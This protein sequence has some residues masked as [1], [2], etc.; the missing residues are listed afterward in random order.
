LIKLIVSDLDGTLLGFDKKI[1]E[2]DKRAIQAAIEHG[3]DFAV[4]SGR[5]DIEI[6]EVLKEIEQKAHRVSQNGAYIYTK[7]DVSLH[8][9]TFEPTVARQ[10]Y[11]EAKQLE[12]IILVCNENTNFVETLTEQVRQL[13]VRLFHDIIEAPNMIKA[14][15]TTIYPSKITV[16]AE[17]DVITSFQQ[18]VTKQF[19]DLVDT[20]ISEERCLD[21]MPKNISKG[22]ALRSLMEHLDVTPEETAC[23]GDSF[24]DIP[25]F[26]LT[27]Y[28]FVMSHAHPDVKKEARYIVDSVNE[29]V[30]IILTEI[31]QVIT[32]K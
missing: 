10:I 3:M 14:I 13:Q 30:Q 32:K 20:F 9:A 31:N 11:Q 19:G 24:N 28:S 23:F 1:K 7:T 29:A 4:A 16:L 21:I 8:S 27:P 6:L 12:A 15:G 2:E 18:Q 22:N 26:R 17:N 25:M 5:M